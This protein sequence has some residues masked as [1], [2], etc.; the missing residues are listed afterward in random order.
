MKRQSLATLVAATLCAVTVSVSEAGEAANRPNVILIMTDDQGYG[1]LSCHG[2][3]NIQTSNIVRI[4]KDGASFAHAISSCPV[5]TPARGAVL[6]EQSADPYQ[7]QNHYDDSAYR[8]GRQ[9]IH[10]LRCRGRLRVGRLIPGFVNCGAVN[11]S[12][13]VT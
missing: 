4:A 6:T 1:D 11:G 13:S 8:D 10:A 3:P 2:N 7:L 9:H 5:C 12:D